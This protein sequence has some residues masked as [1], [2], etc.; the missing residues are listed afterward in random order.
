[1][2]SRARAAGIVVLAGTIIP[3]NT[4][5]PEQNRRMQQVNDWIRPGADTRPQPRDR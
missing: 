5:T 2:Y 3:F 4:A 1:M